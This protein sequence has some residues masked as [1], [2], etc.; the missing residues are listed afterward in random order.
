MLSNL[1]QMSRLQL[2]VSVVQKLWKA[3]AQ[4]ERTRWEEAARPYVSQRPYHVC[5]WIK[6][7]HTHE[8]LHTLGKLL[9]EWGEHP[10]LFGE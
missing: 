2:V 8:H 9:L 10:D 4:C 6:A 3:L 7:G 5:S 1:A